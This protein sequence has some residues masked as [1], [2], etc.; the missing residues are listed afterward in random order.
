M[1]K[2]DHKM[3]SWQ[4]FH[5]ARKHLGTSVLYQIFGKKSA[6]AVD[7]WAQDPR[8]TNKPV[9][10]Y[11]PMQG[12]KTLIELLD[13]N[14]HD[15]VVRCA[16]NFLLSDTSI[17]SGVE[18]NIQDLQSTIAEEVVRDYKAVAEMQAAIEDG[19]AIEWVEA[20]KQDAID[21]ITRTVALYRKQINER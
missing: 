8:F 15:D 13:D 10:A 9:G 21:E 3:Q 18:P 17:S 11:D 14:G 20:L 6:R 12:I 1:S 5:F 4:V 7:L 2:L 16:L 19:E